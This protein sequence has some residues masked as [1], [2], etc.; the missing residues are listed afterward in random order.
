MCDVDEACH[1]LF[2]IRL[3]IFV[4]SGSDVPLAFFNKSAWKKKKKSI[5]LDF[6]ALNQTRVL[7]IIIVLQVALIQSEY[8]NTID[9][10]NTLQ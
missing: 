5:F 6:F 10:G 2:S 9:F 1:F 3:L 4:C 8:V 7:F